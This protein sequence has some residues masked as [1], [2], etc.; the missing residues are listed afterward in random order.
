LSL[1]KPGFGGVGFDEFTGG[2]GAAASSTGGGGA[3]AGRAANL[4]NGI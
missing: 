3:A 2:V 1:S 4:S